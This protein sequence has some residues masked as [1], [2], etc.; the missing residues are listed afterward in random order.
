MLT[1]LTRVARLGSFARVYEVQCVRGDTM[2]ARSH[3]KLAQD[4][5]AKTK[6]SR[7]VHYANIYNDGQCTLVI[8]WIKSTCARTPNIVRFGDCFEMKRTFT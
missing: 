7:L 1:R 6:V 8:R 2:P 5:K 3:E 4:E